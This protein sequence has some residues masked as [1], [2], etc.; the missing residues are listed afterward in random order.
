MSEQVWWVERVRKLRPSVGAMVTYAPGT[1][2]EEH[3]VIVAVGDSAKHQ[4]LAVAEWNGDR[5]PSM[6][7]AADLHV[8][9]V[10]VQSLT[11]LAS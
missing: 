8:G 2:S 6:V 5:R 1:T 4:W 9:L 7:T 3:G 11:R 10:V